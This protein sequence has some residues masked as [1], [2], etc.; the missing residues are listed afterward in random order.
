MP[1]NM[2]PTFLNTI[3]QLIE[4]SKTDSWRMGCLQKTNLEW[5]IVSLYKA[6]TYI[7]SVDNTPADKCPDDFDD[8]DM[9]FRWTWG[10]RQLEWDS[11]LVSVAKSL[12]H[13]QP[14]ALFVLEKLRTH[15]LLFADG[16]IHPL[17]ESSLRSHNE[18]SL[19]AID[20]ERNDLFIKEIDQ[21]N[22]IKELSKSKKP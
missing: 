20:V 22:K 16:R 9:R 17:L 14:S 3:T 11:V 21:R 19:L 7:Y 13:D 6:N 15:G 4:S 8:W 10:Y 2:R 5:E 12:T 18:K 1:V